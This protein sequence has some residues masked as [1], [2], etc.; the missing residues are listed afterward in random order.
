MNQILSNIQKAVDE[1]VLLFTQKVSEK[2]DIDQNELYALWKQTCSNDEMNNDEMNNDEMNNDEI[3]NDNEVKKR[4]ITKKIMP[5]S[6]KEKAAKS[7]LEKK[8]ISAL[9]K[10]C[11]ERGL[12]KFSSLKKKQLIEMLQQNDNDDKKEPAL[13]DVL[14][15]VQENMENLDIQ[16]QVVEKIF[17]KEQDFNEEEIV[18]EY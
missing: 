13:E 12:K 14:D 9:K 2:Y 4:K 17:E 6:N 16:D 11:K 5:K 15:E 18:E 7:P 1:S 10:M 8:S 3:G